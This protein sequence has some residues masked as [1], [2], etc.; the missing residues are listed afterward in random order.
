MARSRKIEQG[1]RARPPRQCDLID[2]RPR[3]CQAMSADRTLVLHPPERVRVQPQR[4]PP[5]PPPPFFCPTPIRSRRRSAGIH[6]YMGDIYRTRF[7]LLA[8]KIFRQDPQR[9]GS[10][11]GSSPAESSKDRLASPGLPRASTLKAA[12]HTP[13]GLP[14]SM[15]GTING[16]PNKENKHEF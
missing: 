15:G 5:P 11:A 16:Y 2:T 14:R 4:G 8:R 6:A 12:I 3:P 1:Q 7:R 13:S 9:A 10:S